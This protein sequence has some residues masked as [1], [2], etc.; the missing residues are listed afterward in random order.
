M[1]LGRKSYELAMDIFRGADSFSSAP[2]ITHLNK[3]FSFA[4][5]ARK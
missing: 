3:Y 5:G 1:R 2:G 4:E